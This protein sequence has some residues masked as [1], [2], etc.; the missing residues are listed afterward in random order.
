MADD[1]TRAPATR[2][3]QPVIAQQDWIEKLVGESLPEELFTTV[4]WGHRLIVVRDRPIETTKGGIIVPTTAQREMDTGWVVSI[5][6]R[7]GDDDAFAATYPG[8]SPFVP[9]EELVGM[10]VTFGKYAGAALFQRKDTVG[11]TSYE[12]RFVILTDGDIM[13][14]HLNNKEPTP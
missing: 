13:F 10:R 7:V 8:V 1:T 12:S 2:G 9:P 3:R 11:G 4:P 6:D 14:H 5:G